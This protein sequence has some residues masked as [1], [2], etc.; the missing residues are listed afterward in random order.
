M[1]KKNISRALLGAMISEIQPRG[2]GRTNGAGNRLAGHN[3]ERTVAA[4][5]REAGFIHTV[6]SRSESRSRDNDKVDLINKNEILN[7]RLPYNI[8]CKNAVKYVKYGTLLKEM[9]KDSGAMNVI[10]HKLTERKGNKFHPVGHY[11]IMDMEDF[12]KMTERILQ[13]EFAVKELKKDD[14]SY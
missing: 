11:A 9:P 3:L 4:R 10:I 8:S 13:L 5:M 7:G 2:K 12:M 14:S 1:D 6:S